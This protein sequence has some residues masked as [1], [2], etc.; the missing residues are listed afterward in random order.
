[1]PWS[2]PAGCPKHHI[3]ALERLVNSYPAKWL[4]QPQ[5]GEEFDSLDYYNR[6]LRAFA[7]AKGFDIIRNGRGTKNAP[8][9]RF[10]YFYYGITTKNNRK[11]KDRVEANKKKNINSKRKRN[12]TNIR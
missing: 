4:L 11:L 7:L 10:R 12:T 3:A 5:T 8:S 2:A 9:Y 1:M 6:R